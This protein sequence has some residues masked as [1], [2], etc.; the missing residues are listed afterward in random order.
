MRIKI[1]IKTRREE[2][3]YLV[4]RLVLPKKKN[5]K[6]VPPDDNEKQIFVE[7][8]LINTPRAFP[9]ISTSNL[10]VIWYVGT[11]VLRDFSLKIDSSIPGILNYMMKFL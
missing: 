11:L 2:N 7:Y 4:R 3:I 5:K 6:L 8:S 1:N 9:E 10:F